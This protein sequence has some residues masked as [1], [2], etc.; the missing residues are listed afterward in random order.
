MHDN[1]LVWYALLLLQEKVGVVT[2]DGKLL[3]PRWVIKD[4]MW[5]S[6]LALV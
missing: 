4:M 3:P 6:M 2:A 1:K 5:Q